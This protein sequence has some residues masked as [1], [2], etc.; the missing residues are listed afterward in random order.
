LICDL[1]CPKNEWRML[2]TNR[3]VRSSSGVFQHISF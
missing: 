3:N 1:C 2:E